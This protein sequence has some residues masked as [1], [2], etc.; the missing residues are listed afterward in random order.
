MKPP[1][2]Y[3]GR[4]QTY[5][6][7]FFLE[8]YLERVA[9]NILWSQKEFVYVDGFSGPWQSE[10]EVFEDTSFVI[11]LNQ[12]RKVRD[13][14]RNRGREVKIRCLFN[15]NEPDAYKALAGAVNG[16]EDIEIKV[17]CHDF[18]EVVPKFVDYVGKSFSLTFYR[19]NG[20]ERLRSGKDKP[21]FYPAWGSAYQLYAGSREE[22]L[23]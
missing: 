23:G 20:M 18:E 12:L 11:A 6:K 22:V 2:F 10:D 14:L 13:E 5:V 3:R 4:E 21:P 19:S 8:R 9:Y 17:L 15:D 1:D 7:H 16:V